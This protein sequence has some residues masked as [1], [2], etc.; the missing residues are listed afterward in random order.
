MSK[1]CPNCK[2]KMP[3]ESNFCLKCMN[4]CDNSVFPSENAIISASNSSKDILISKLKNIRA[5]FAALPKKRK[6]ALISTIL[7]L[8]ALIPLSVYLFSPIDSPTGLSG[9]ITDPNYE[10]SDG[11]P[12]SRAEAF[13]NEIFGTDNDNNSG[14]PTLTQVDDLPATNETTGTTTETTINEGTS[15]TS[16]S[17]TKPQNNSNNSGNNTDTEQENSNSEPVLNYGDWEYEIDGDDVIITKYTGKDLNIIVPD[18]IEGLNLYRVSKNTFANNSNLQTIT[19]KNSEDYHS[20]WIESGAFNN[21]RALK[22]ITFPNN[23]NLGIKEGFAID[24]PS[25]STI[26]IDFWQYRSVNGG[27]YSYNGSSWSL[28]FYCEGYNSSTLNIPEWC[29]SVTQSASKNIS[30][31]PYLEIVNIPSNCTGLQQQWNDFEYKN[32]LEVNV[33]AD[34]TYN[35]KSENGVLYHYRN[36]FYDLHIYPGGKAD[37]TFRVIENGN[38]NCYGMKEDIYPYVETIYLP[39]TAVIYSDTLK[40]IYYYFPNLKTIYIEK[41]H[42]NYTEYKNTLDSI[43]NVV[44]Y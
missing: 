20:C 2:A 25:L 22:Q 32:L 13:F 12:I 21:C 41:G 27:L 9:Y 17:S 42:P 14:E 39:K 5:N 43:V 16:E 4:I 29:S 26:D 30:N 11:K 7:C 28:L 8:I 38:I 3:D 40:R 34:N 6:F 1:L 35:L 24:V 15:N 10:N 37:K 19:F 36:G 18:K 23:T 31:N 44:E 33:D